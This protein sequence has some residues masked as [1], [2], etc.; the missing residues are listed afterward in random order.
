MAPWSWK[1]SKC[2]AAAGVLR[3]LIDAAGQLS[4]DLEDELSK[5]LGDPIA[6]AMLMGAKALYRQ[7]KAQSESV[8]SQTEEYLRHEQSWKVSRD[9]LMTLAIERA[10]CAIA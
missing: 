4:V 9:V 1:V 10:D 8:K 2:K 5:K 3:S 7:L 6:G